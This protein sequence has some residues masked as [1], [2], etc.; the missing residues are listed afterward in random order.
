MKSN[1]GGVLEDREKKQTPA[2]K[3]EVS[4][5]RVEKKSK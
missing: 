5:I 3:E 4:G 1:W 2:K